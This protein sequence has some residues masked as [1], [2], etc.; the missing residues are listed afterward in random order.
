MEKLKWYD[1]VAC[2]W[3]ADMITVG[4][5]SANI[6]LLTFG[7]FLYIMYENAR[8]GESEWD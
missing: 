6:I 3:C 4:L 8:K 5:L 1:Y 2:V 7:V